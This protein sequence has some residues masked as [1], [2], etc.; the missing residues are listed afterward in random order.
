MKI[1]MTST[2]T[3]DMLAWPIGRPLADIIRDFLQDP[4]L[5]PIE[6]VDSS[7]PV[8]MKILK[9]SRWFRPR[10]AVEF[11][12][13]GGA[14]EFNCPSGSKSSRIFQNFHEYR[15]GTVHT[16]DGTEYRLGTGLVILVSIIRNHCLQFVSN[17]SHQP[18]EIVIDQRPSNQRSNLLGLGVGRQRGVYKCARWISMPWLPVHCGPHARG[19]VPHRCSRPRAPKGARV[20]ERGAHSLSGLPFSGPRPRKKGGYATPLGRFKTLVSL[21]FFQKRR[22][23]PTRRPVPCRCPMCRR[24]ARPGAPAG[25]GFTRMEHRSRTVLKVYF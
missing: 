1:L 10:R 16:L 7:V 4:I 18:N 13:A 22:V 5:C 14:I 23:G 12:R 2:M 17:R 19:F 8:F 3:G 6:S 21:E 9:N 24:R 25:R 15:D 20:H 11:D